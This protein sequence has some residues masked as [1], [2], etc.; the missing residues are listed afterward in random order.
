MRQLMSSQSV[1]LG[2]ETLRMSNAPCIETEN[3]TNLICE[4]IQ[5]AC[6]EKN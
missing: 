5:I 2:G 4:K 1:G 6:A 3:S